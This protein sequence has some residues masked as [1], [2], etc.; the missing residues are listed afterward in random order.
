MHKL[1][2]LQAPS[3]LKRYKHGRD[4]WSLVTDSDKA[5]IWQQLHAMQQ[6]RCAYCEAMIDSTPGQ[7]NA[8]IE[9]FRQRDRYPQGTYDWSNIFGSCNRKDSCGKHKDDQ[10]YQPEHLLKMD[11]DD[12]E[13]FLRF[14]FDGTVHPREALSSHSRHRAEETIRV[15]NLNN[16]SLRQ[17]RSSH[18]KGYRQTA[19][20]LAELALQ[21]EP[22][23]WFELLNDEL[24]EVAGLP[25][26][27]AIRHLL[28][29]NI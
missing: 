5:E 26:E 7:G 10:R 29:F 15:F 6:Y 20:E 16:G 1:I 25:F 22:E 23:D 12:P 19:E 24:E 17:S 3:C 8:H 14:I 9:H 2:R 18:L 4:R 21:L 13:V 27:T 28:Q 11:Q